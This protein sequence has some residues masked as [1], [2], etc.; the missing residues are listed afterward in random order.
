MHG[1]V[2]RGPAGAE[3]T[4]VI[5]WATRRSGP[6]L[7]GPRDHGRFASGSGHFRCLRFHDGLFHGAGL[8]LRALLRPAAGNNGVFFGAAQQLPAPPR[9]ATP[10]QHR[11]G[12]LPPAPPRI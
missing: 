6:V 12:A 2:L 7:G 5:D 11:R 3:A 1:K 8:P 4:E 10:W 9:S